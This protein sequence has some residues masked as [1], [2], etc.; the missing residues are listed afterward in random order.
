MPSGLVA[1]R[2]LVNWGGEHRGR[3]RVEQIADCPPG[4]DDP[5]LM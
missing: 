2:T 3:D 5:A 4:L 1:D